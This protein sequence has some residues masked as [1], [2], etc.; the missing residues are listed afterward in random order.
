MHIFTFMRPLL[1]LLFVLICSE[2]YMAQAGRVVSAKHSLLEQELIRIEPEKP[3]NR[4]GLANALL[5][6]Y[7]RHIS[8]LISA[9]CLYTLSCSR[10]SRK[11]IH[12]HGLVKGVLLTADRLSR[13]AGFCGKDIPDYK[14][15]EEGLAEDNP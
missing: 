15:N 12:T 5:T 9:E 6:F 4:R 7:Q 8:A 2:K 11:A 13:C 14:I 3:S 10:F 1:L